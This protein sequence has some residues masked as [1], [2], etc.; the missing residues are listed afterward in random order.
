[1]KLYL[2]IGLPIVVNADV[3]QALVP[4]VSRLVSTRVRGCN[5]LLKRG[6]GTSADAAGTSARATS[7]RPNTCENCR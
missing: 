3:A 1:M 7:S 4:A 5:T 2:A 6:V